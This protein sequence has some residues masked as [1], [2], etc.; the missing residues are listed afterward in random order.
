[1]E[2]N[3]EDFILVTALN[4]VK[5]YLLKPSYFD[6]KRIQEIIKEVFETK[7]AKEIEIII[8]PEPT[9]EELAEIEKLKKRE[10]LEAKLKALDD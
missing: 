3:K 6:K 1:M 4:G 2:L 7:E 8:E 10:E 5:G 9:E